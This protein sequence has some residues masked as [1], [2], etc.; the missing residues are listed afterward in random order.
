MGNNKESLCHSRL[1]SLSIF[2]CL[3]VFSRVLLV[4][5][6]VRANRILTP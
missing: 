5:G 2:F 4:S 1:D 6:V 3:L